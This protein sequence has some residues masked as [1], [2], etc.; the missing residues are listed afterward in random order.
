MTGKYAGLPPEGCGNACGCKGCSNRWGRG[1]SSPNAKVSLSGEQRKANGIGFTKLDNTHRLLYTVLTFGGAREE[2]EELYCASTGKSDINDAVKAAP[3]GAQSLYSFIKDELIMTQEPFRRMN[4]GDVLGVY[5]I[6]PLIACRFEYCGH[7]KLTNWI[8]LHLNLY[9]Y[10]SEKYDTPREYL[11]NI[12][13]LSAE[14]KLLHRGDVVAHHGAHCKWENEVLQEYANGGYTEAMKAGSEY[15]QEL[16]E[17]KALSIPG[18]KAFMR[19][20]KAACGMNR[21][22]GMSEI[23]RLYHRFEKESFKEDR[24]VIK[25]WLLEL[26]RSALRGEM[27]DWKRTDTFSEGLQELLE[28]GI[29]RCAKWEE[30]GAK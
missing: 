5:E 24:E 20:A 23:R 15:T 10:W 21:K 13:G 14:A 16:W 4:D 9:L 11:A 28:T 12:P 26:A 8:L 17:K 6:L 7:P 27:D 30:K 25:K 19:E 22:A 3:Q 29:E 1:G 18:R 2:I